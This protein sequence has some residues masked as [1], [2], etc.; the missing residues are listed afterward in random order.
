M[1]VEE[2]RE[3]AQSFTQWQWIGKN[4]KFNSVS[5]LSLK[6]HLKT[7]CAASIAHVFPPRSIGL[8]K[9]SFKLLGS[10]YPI[11]ILVCI[12]SPT[13]PYLSQSVI[14]WP[15]VAVRPPEEFVISLVPVWYPPLT[16]LPQH[17]MLFDKH[18]QTICAFCMNYLIASHVYSFQ[19]VFTPSQ[20]PSCF[21]KCT[22]TGKQ[23]TSWLGANA[24]NSSLLYSTT[25][26][27]Y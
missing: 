8:L 22:W 24:H 21:C 3:A 27:I 23:Q 11:V 12:P 25:L 10:S 6:S 7:N 20:D 26:L 16:N 13:E 9:L 15:C 18:R 19:S 2:F 4:W 5:L 1:C 17:H 14:R